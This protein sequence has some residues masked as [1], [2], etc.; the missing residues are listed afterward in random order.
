MQTNKKKL[1]TFI[2]VMLIIATICTLCFAC[3]SGCTKDKTDEPQDEINVGF[4]DDKQPEQTPVEPEEPEEDD[5]VYSL[6]NIN[7]ASAEKMD[8]PQSVNVQATIYPFNASDKRLN[9]SLAWKNA[10]SEWSSDKKVTDY[11]TCTANEQDSTIATITQLYAFGEPITLTV[12]SVKY[13]DKTASVELN[14]EAEIT[15]FIASFKY[16]GNYYEFTKDGFGDE[17]ECDIQ[18]V[19]NEYVTDF[20]ITYILPSTYTKISNNRINLLTIGEFKHYHLNA[21][22]GYEEYDYYLKGF[23]DIPLFANEEIENPNFNFEATLYSDNNGN[24][25]EEHKELKTKMTFEDFFKKPVEEN[26]EFN[27]LNRY[28]GGINNFLK[29]VNSAFNEAEF[30]FSITFNFSEN[31]D[32]NKLVAI[33]FN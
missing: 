24:E 19:E 6:A 16:A 2:S 25:T 8:E 13:P 23:G 11:V 28:A 14:C 5:K 22:L 26:E 31:N 18:L 20:N 12:Q 33:N 32:Y 3:L 9:W 10:S 30:P 29:I 21:G 17:R 27:M 15:D 1:S 4:D 7:F